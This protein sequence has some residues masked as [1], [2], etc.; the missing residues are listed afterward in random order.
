MDPS[1]AARDL[2]SLSWQEGRPLVCR[3]R[4]RE[5]HVKVIARIVAAFALFSMAPLASAAPLRYDFTGTCTIGCVNI[6]L[7][8]GGSVSGFILGQDFNTN[9]V[10][11]SS[12]LVDF[13]F[14]FG[15]LAISSSTHTAIGA[16][17]LTP[18]GNI[19]F[20]APISGMSFVNLTTSATTGSINLLGA[21]FS[22]WSVTLPGRLVPRVAGGSGAYST[23]SVPEPGTLAL[24]GL[25]LAGLG[26]ARRRRADR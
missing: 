23:A 13:G 3:Y 9:L 12:E 8:T 26:L 6:G 19:D 7:S 17:G 16:L 11:G 10:L 18:A 25:G 4:R 22:G 20:G 5:A 14:T 24:L 15:T 2:L 21:S 1:R